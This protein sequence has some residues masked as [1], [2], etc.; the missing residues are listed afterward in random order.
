MPV[1]GEA[2]QLIKLPD[3]DPQ[4]VDLGRFPA[5]TGGTPGVSSSSRCC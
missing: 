1:G 4:A 2:S 3:R 5:G